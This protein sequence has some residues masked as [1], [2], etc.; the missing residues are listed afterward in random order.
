MN[1]FGMDAP[2]NKYITWAKGFYYLLAPPSIIGAAI[3]LSVS[4]T[5]LSYTT[6]ESPEQREDF[7]SRV[8]ALPSPSELIVLK[9]H[10]DNSNLHIDKSKMDS[11]YVSRKEL[12]EMIRNTSID[13]YNMNRKLDRLSDNQEEMNR[14]IN[15]MLIKLDNIKLK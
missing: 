9:H 4:W 8:K 5:K 15:L 14:R 7:F 12:N 1:L 2:D 6:F 11:L 10:A 3:I 13:T